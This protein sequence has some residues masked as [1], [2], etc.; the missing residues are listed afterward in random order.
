MVCVRCL[1]TFQRHRKFGAYSDGTSFPQLYPSYIQPGEDAMV[2]FDGYAGPD[3]K[4]VNSAQTTVAVRASLKDNTLKI[5]IVGLPIL[6]DGVKV[7]PAFW[8]R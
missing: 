4:F 2:S 3:L 8:R 7:T 5:S 1:L 6:E